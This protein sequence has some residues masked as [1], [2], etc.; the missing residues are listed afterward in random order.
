MSVC[1]ILA[2]HGRLCHDEGAIELTGLVG[3]VGL[4]ALP[5]PVPLLLLP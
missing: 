2:A 4:A 5:P 1:W 3:L